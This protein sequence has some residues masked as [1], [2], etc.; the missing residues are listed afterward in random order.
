MDYELK[1][2]AV[3]PA[4]Y[5]RLKTAVGWGGGN[6]PQKQVEMG[7][8]NTLFSV[9]AVHQG[10]VIGMGRLV[11]DGVIICYVQDVIVLPEFQGMGIG[12]AIMKRLMEFVESNGMA[13]TKISVGLFAAKGKE[14]FYEKLGFCARGDG[15]SGP[16][17]EM[18][19]KL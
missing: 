13:G 4:D 9:A 17:M 18:V 1:E 10:Q 15:D 12:R 19:V 8:K 3:V 7:L 5:L 11:G 16:G 14:P 2:N 6:A